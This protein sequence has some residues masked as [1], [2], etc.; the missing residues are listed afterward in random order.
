MSCDCNTLIVGEAGPQGPQG[1]AGT[2][3]TNGTNG[4]NAFTTLSA[5]FV[6][7]S[8]SSTVTITVGTNQWM[9]IGQAIYISQAGFYTVSS[10][11]GTTQAVV[12]L[13]KTDGISPAGTVSASRKISPSAIATYAAPLSSLTVNGDS[14]L[15]GNVVINQAGADKDFRVEG[16]TDIN[17]LQTDAGTDRVGVGIASPQAKLHVSGAF[18]VGV[19]GSGSDALFT[20][21]AIFNDNSSSLGDFEVRSVNLSSAFFVDAS[22][23]RVGIG[24]NSP[25]K[26]LDVAGA[27]ETNSILVNPGGVATIDALKVIG[28]VSTVV[29]FIVNASNSRVGIGISSPTVQL[30]ISGA[31]KISGDLAVDTSVLFVDTSSNYVGVNTSTP[32]YPLSVSGAANIT[33]NTTIGG[34]LGA[35]ATTVASVSVTGTASVAG[36][37]TVDT[38]V[39]FV[40]TSNNFVGVNTATAVTDAALAVAG[41]DFIVDTSVL[42][43][44]ASTNR[45]GI[46]DSTPSVALEVAGSAIIT[47]SLTVDTNTLVVDATTN[48]VA[49]GTATPASGAALTIAGGDL[50]VNTSSLVVDYSTSRVGVNNTTPAVPLDISGTVNINGALQRNAPVTKNADFSVGATENWIIVNNGA[51]TVVTLP[52]ASSWTGREIMMK[53]IQAQ[54]VNSNAVNVVSISGVSTSSILTNTAGKFATLVSD[55]SYWEIMAGN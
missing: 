28:S 24:T 50:V 32:A 22:T 46:N 40:D 55:G 51:T 38:N 37:L 3:G 30:D 1:L 27:M 16:D 53:T 14:D 6:Q 49:I 43:V 29:P 39:L 10:L 13:V 18:K 9:A 54:A 7:P 11:S 26:L 45:V 33:G 25:S 15:D 23:D 20:R 34:T 5:S 44:D 48:Q 47:Q 8:V 36:N 52:T 21:G 19:A 42:F 31:V 35:G 2:N 41:G 17:L 12:T 4:V